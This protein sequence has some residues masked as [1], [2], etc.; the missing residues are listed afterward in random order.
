MY[1]CNVLAVPCIKVDLFLVLQALD[2]M[3]KAGS[4]L[5]KDQMKRL[6]KEVCSAD[7]S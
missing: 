6:E 5:P 7:P 3:K 2:M 4:S 1:C